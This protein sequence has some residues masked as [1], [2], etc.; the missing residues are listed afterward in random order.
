MAHIRN[1]AGV[2]FFKAEWLNMPVGEWVESDVQAT[3][4]RA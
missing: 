2:T 1:M 3:V 4:W